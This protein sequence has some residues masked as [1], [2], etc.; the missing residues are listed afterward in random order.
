MATN[1]DLQYRG[2]VSLLKHFGWTWVGIFVRDDE[3]G[4]RFL[5]TMELLLSQNGICSAFTERMPSQGYVYDKKRFDSV[6]HSLHQIFRLT[7]CRTFFLY[8]NTYNLMYL[9]HQINQALGEKNSISAGKVWII[10]AQI[11]FALARLS[12][13]KDLQMFQGALSFMIHSNEVPGFQEFLQTLKPDWTEAD[14]F[15]K[16]FWEEAF[17]CSFPNRRI[18]YKVSGTCTGEERL[19]SLIA[20]LF[21]MRMCGHSYSIYNAVYAV[22]HALQA[23]YSTN[24][25][26]RTMVTGKKE[27]HQDLSPWQLHPYLQGISFNTSTGERVA[28]NDDWEFRAG[29][30]IMNLVTFPNRSF[31][32][33]K[34]GQVDPNA[35]GGNPFSINDT[36]ITW[37]KSF[38]QVLPCSV[39]SEFC[40]PGFEKRKKEG[41]KFCCYD[42]IQCPEGKI[43]N[44]TDVDDCSQCPEDQYPNKDQSQCIPKVI[45][46]L[47]YEDALGKSLALG[48]IFFSLMTAV[49]LGTFV[50]HSGTPIVKA[51]NWKLTYILLV[52]LLLCFLSSFLFLGKPG[53]LTCLLQQPIFGIIFTVAVS[54]VL[55]KTITVIVAFMATK[56]GSNMKKWVGK[57]M[58]TSIIISCSIIQL[59]ICATWLGTS[60]PFPDLDVNSVVGEIIIQCN[61]G[62]FV[63]FYLVLGYMGLLSLI[64]FTVAFLV[65]KLP[66]SFNESKFITFSM[67]I[68]CT[69]WL[70]F[71]PTYL[72]TRGTD[73][74][75][76]EIF[77]I[78]ASS[79][80]LLCCIFAPKCYIIV[81]K[82]ELNTKEQLTRKRTQA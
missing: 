76:V 23:L 64:S 67:L 51:N 50:K 12:R 60:P 22:A 38:N 34:V 57:R 25:N 77:S 2:M 45:T 73:M 55:A 42:C 43:S 69:V 79:A 37:H 32:N 3:S 11:D 6:I 20:P 66:D 31:V 58:A 48:A 30:D 13:D 21:E 47:S 63:F 19:E 9:W 75:A 18:P 1:E 54:C 36:T 61:E 62:S 78:L 80:G 44:Q 46:F 16:D 29:F 74:V 82:S 71:V 49:V 7:N 4:E 14:G 24:S 41:E 27:V 40:H 26:R 59:G 17:D 52:S 5:E 10:T 65:R 53:K 70:S 81:L 15:L 33:V 28:F 68:F 56:P 35:P 39:C 72:S 8:G